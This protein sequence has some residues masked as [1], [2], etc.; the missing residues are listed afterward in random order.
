MDVGGRNP[1]H[2][3]GHFLVE[4]TDFLI[5]RDVGSDISVHG[6][7]ERHAVGLTGRRWRRRLSVVLRL[8][9]HIHFDSGFVGG[10]P[11]DDA[12]VATAS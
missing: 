10:L 4:L 11:E 8:H 12:S 5:A 6:H 2:V 1:V 9:L 3:F 7:G